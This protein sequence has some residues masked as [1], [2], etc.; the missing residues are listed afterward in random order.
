M[1]LDIN[2]FKTK[3]IMNATDADG[4]VANKCNDNNK[5]ICF[6]DCALIP[7]RDQ[8][9]V[10]LVQTGPNWSR[11]LLVKDLVTSDG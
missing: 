9:E 5:K 11:Q 6:I 1:S 10:P 2:L 3:D 7:S 4:S 8:G